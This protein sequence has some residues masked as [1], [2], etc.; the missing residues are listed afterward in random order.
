[1]EKKSHFNDETTTHVHNKKQN[2]IIFAKIW[3][4]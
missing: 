2:I 4:I 1:M 3:K